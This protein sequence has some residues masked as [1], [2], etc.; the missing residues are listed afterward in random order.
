MLQLHQKGEKYQMQQSIEAKAAAAAYA[1]D[2]RRKNPDK[3]RQYRQRYWE[4]K[5]E[6]AKDKP[7]KHES[8]TEGAFDGQE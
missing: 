6:A 7:V 8:H 5:A 1:R 4:K 3:C 2:W